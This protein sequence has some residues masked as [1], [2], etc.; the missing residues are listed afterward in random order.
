MKRTIIRSCVT[1]LFVSLVAVCGAGETGKNKNTKA[2]Q[3]KTQADTSC[4]AKETSVLTGSRLKSTY[5]RRGLITD[6][7]SQ[8]MVLDRKAIESSGASDLRELLTRKGLR[9]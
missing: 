2:A 8:V 5:T 1:A 7:Q 4:S 9:R 6:G 3:Q